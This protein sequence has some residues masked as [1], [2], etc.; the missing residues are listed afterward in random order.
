MAL[1]LIKISD[2]PQVNEPSEW[3][4]VADANGIGYKISKADFKD[5]LG[6][7][8]VVAPKALAPTDPTP[9]LD[10]VYKPTVDG[11]YANAGGLTVDRSESG[12][13]YGMSVEFI[14]NGATWVKVTEPMPQAE[15]KIPDWIAGTYTLGNQ[16]IWKGEIWEVVVATTNKEPGAEMGDESAWEWR[17]KTA[18][19]I[20]IKTEGNNLLVVT[21]IDNNVLFRINKRGY[22]RAKISESDI[23]VTGRVEEGE[24]RAVSGDAVF[25]KIKSLGEHETNNLLLVEDASGNTIAR[26]DKHGGLIAKYRDSSIEL[27]VINGLEAILDSISTQLL[28][29]AEETTNDI[30]GELFRIQDKSG[31]V[32]ASID[33]GGTLKVKKLSA[34]EIEGVTDSETIS[35]NSVVTELEELT[36]PR[37]GFL[38]MNVVGALP[39]DSSPAR[40][41]TNVII[42]LNNGIEDLVTFGAEMS[43]Q[44]SG[45]A[46]YFKKGYNI[47]MVNANGDDFKLKIGDMIATD[48]YHVK[49]FHTDITHTRDVGNG[50]L[51]QEMYQ[52]RSYPYNFVR[53]VPPPTEFVPLDEYNNKTM[54][55]EDAKFFPDGIPCQIV[56]GG[57][58]V[59]LYTFRL[60]KT[61]ENYALD[62]DNENHIF[63]E[64]AITGRYMGNQHY[65]TY[66]DWIEG[67]E[68][69]T[70][71][72]ATQNTK[73]NILRFFNWW[74][75]VYNGDV[76]LSDTYQ[77]YIVLESWIDFYIA[78][79]LIGHRDINGNNTL[80]NTYDG[81]HWQI[82]LYDTDNSIGIYSTLNPPPAGLSISV[83]IWT[84]V[85]TQLLPQIK[86]RYQFLREAG[87]FS[88]ENFK[89]IYGGISENIPRNVYE[90]NYETWGCQTTNG[91][92]TME[93][94]YGFLNAR[95]NTLDNLW[96]NS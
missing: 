92:P 83:D 14:K 69:R 51:W 66:E 30:V 49:A 33:K 16:R 78:A 75:D 38:T 70:P 23:P 7:V 90:Q 71:R 24:A 77:D 18:S 48:S 21:D 36:I 60:K 76:S 81:T 22:L 95:L 93:Q 87:V 54:Y 25:E 74:E 44:G 13:D 20:L 65:E 82:F 1:E 84:A 96:I 34:S 35:P 61:R 52:T 67:W 28:I 12:A 31:N 26:I 59:G 40:T 57:E 91:I 56:T 8:T 85:R 42:T 94:I 79:E 43:I 73:D 6:T 39:T 72:T 2:F 58:F 11:T 63:V 32:L 10:G 62:R 55:T 64:N 17:S 80:I 5:W 19:N 3:I 47:D 88:N 15:N 9:T 4:A 86:D 53:P 41:P 46:G 68:L 29:F 37:Y 89:K 50:R 45:S 27:P